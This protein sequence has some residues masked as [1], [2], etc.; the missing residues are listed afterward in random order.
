MVVGV[1]VKVKSRKM[2]KA[3][4]GLD[5]GGTFIKGVVIENEEVTYQTT[6]ETQDHL[7]RWK[8]SAL[9]YLA[10]IGWSEMPRRFRSPI[11]RNRNNKRETT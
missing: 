11:A 3:V 4:L 5:I 6:L 1:L 7:N 8:E 10:A 2:S 9:G